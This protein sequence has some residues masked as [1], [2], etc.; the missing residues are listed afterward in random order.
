MEITFTKL[1]DGR[2]CRWSAV[3][4]PRSEVPGPTMAVGRDLPHD[5]AT[6]VIEDALALEYGFWGCVAAGARFRTLGR[7]RTPPGTAV[8]AAHREELDAAEAEVNRVYFD[9]REG[10]PTAVDAALDSTLAEWRALPDGGELR[11]RWVGVG[12][13]RRNGRSAR[14]R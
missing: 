9:W 13:P 7:R 12:E 5:L 3:R 11:R 14:R 6:F 2:A 10:R 8:I 4:P 1:R